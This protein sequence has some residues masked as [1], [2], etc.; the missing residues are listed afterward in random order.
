[1]K[2]LLIGPPACGKGTVGELLSEKLG[3]PVISI[4][5]LLREIPETHPRYSELH[6]LMDSGE[7]APHDL[8]AEVLKKRL[9]DAD[10]ARGFLLDGYLRNIV[11]L[12]HFDP[13]VDVALFIDIEPETSIKRISGRRICEA[14]DFT[15]NIFTMSEEDPH[16][17]KRCSGELTQRADDAEE[18]VRERL[19]VYA[20]ETLPVVDHYK[21]LGMLRK[22]DGEG[23]PEE[24]FELALAALK[25]SDSN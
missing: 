7:L 11:Q 16:N 5:G 4:G 23:T 6:T 15:C 12:E 18:V 2:I 14:D 20:E 21:K 3:F 22:I 1:M 13:R 10:C 8:V 9:E 17:C 19:E 24:V 25:N